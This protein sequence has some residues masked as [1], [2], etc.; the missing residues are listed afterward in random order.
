MKTQESWSAYQIEDWLVERIAVILNIDANEIDPDVP[1][2]SLGLDSI[3]VMDMIVELDNLLGIE[4]E[5]TIAWDF[6]TIRL[7]CGY[8]ATLVS[9]KHT[10][11]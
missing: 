1:F 2:N 9:E 5:S 11:K 6:P 4:I 3:N 7:L 10:P 8:V